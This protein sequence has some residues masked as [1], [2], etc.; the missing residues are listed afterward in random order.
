MRFSAVQKIIDK[1]R[2][3]EKTTWSENF[4]YNPDMITRASNM[5]SLL[6]GAEYGS[7]LDLGCG[8]QYLREVIPDNV[9]YIGVDQYQHKKDTIICDFNKKQFPQVINGEEV[10]SDIVFIA[11]LL[12]YLKYKKWLLKEACKASDKYILLSYN[13]KEFVNIP[14]NIWL[15]LSSQKEILNVMFDNSFRLSKLIKDPLSG[16][17]NVT[18]YMLFEKC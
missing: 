7:I 8:I 17:V 14:A 5:L 4:T 6:D 18:L 11:G 13:F 9:R 10:H 2:V 12:E 15:P 1:I 3:K 16:K